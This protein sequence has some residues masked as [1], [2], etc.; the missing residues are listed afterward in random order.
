MP[1]GSSST[2]ARCGS[3]RS[4][5]ASF[6]N[7]AWKAAVLLGWSETFDPEYVALTQLHADALIAL[8][9]QLAGAVK[10]LVTADRRCRW[11]VMMQPYS[12][13][14]GVPEMP[15]G[16]HFM[17]RRRNWRCDSRIC[18]RFR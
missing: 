17:S 10:D 16:S 12:S 14:A 8:D 1:N 6:Q 5:T 11:G 15:I 13:A 7:V 9:R 2:C 4:G 3:G 18:A